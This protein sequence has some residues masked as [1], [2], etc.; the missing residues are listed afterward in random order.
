MNKMFLSMAAAV[1]A[2]MMISAPVSAQ[3]TPPAA[4]VTLSLTATMPNLRDNKL[5]NTFNGKLTDAQLRE[6]V[7]LK[8]TAGRSKWALFHTNKVCGFQQGSAVEIN[9]KGVWSPRV[10][11][12]GYYEVT[13]SGSTDASKLTYGYQPVGA[14]AASAA[15][16]TGEMVL[17]P[18]LASGG[19]KGLVDDVLAGI[20]AKE[21]GGVI[22]TETDTITFNNLCVPSGG[23][24]SDKGTCFS[25]DG[26]YSYQSFSWFFRLSA[27]FADQVYALEGNMPFTSPAIP[28]NTNMDKP[29]VTEYNVTLTDPKFAGTAAAGGDEDAALFAEFDADAGLGNAP[30]GITGKLTMKNTGYVDVQIGQETIPVA[31]GVQLDG[32][33]HGNEIPLPVVRAFAKLIVEILPETFVG[34]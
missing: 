7:T 23:F 24:P 2:V 4:D 9:V 30:K 28:E 3:S 5:E 8:C 21:G 33:L 17:K 27:K 32:T 11:I 25:G 26:V 15:T 6:S 16:Y 29:T 34:P 12:G 18:E 22:N 31:S 20:T 14:V 13:E 1:A 19:A 10:L